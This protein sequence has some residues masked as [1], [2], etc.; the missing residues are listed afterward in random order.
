MIGNAS[1][2]DLQT[3]VF[4]FILRGVSLLGISS[5]NCAMAL[6]QAV[7]DRLGAELKP[8]AL[9]RVVSDTVPLRDV[10][11]A[12]GRLMAR[13]SLGRILVDCGAAPA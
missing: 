6:R 3:T 10:V 12:A 7:W 11:A 4:P 1:G 2:A 8:A 9:E 13:S 5:A